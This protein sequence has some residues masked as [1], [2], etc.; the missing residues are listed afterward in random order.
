VGN[1]GGREKEEGNKRGA[2]TGT[3]RDRRDVQ[4]IRKLNRN[5]L[6]CK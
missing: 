5:M 6:K 1:I 2:G 3:G 4:R